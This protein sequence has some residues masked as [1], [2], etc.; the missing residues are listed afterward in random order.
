MGNLLKKFE[1]NDTQLQA[2]SCVKKSHVSINN[3]DEENICYITA[4]FWIEKSYINKE[5]KR[6]KWLS[7]LRT[8]T[9]QN[10]GLGYEKEIN[11]SFFI[12]SPIILTHQVHSKAKIKFVSNSKFWPHY[13]WTKK[14]GGNW[15]AIVH[16]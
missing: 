5:R 8:T 11:Y 14:L 7:L 12:M 13:R 3:L 2:K 6:R 16:L 9:H 1:L 10:E 4:L 15:E